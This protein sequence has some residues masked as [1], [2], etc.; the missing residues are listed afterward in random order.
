MIKIKFRFIYDLLKIAV[1]LLI[2][3]G[4]TIFSQLILDF[5]G[6]NVSFFFTD[7]FSKFKEYYP[8]FYLIL[9]IGSRT[10]KYL[11]PLFLILPVFKHRIFLF[12]ILY[13]KFHFDSITK[14][15]KSLVILFF[16]N[17]T[18][19]IGLYYLSVLYSSNFILQLRISR[20]FLIIQLILFFVIV[21]TNRVL[22]GQKV[23]ANLK[24][25][26][27][28]Y[29]LALTRILF[30]TYSIFLYLVVFPFSTNSFAGLTKVSLPGIS[31]L[32]NIWPISDSLYLWMCYLGAFSALMVAIG[33]KTRLF[34]II[35]CFTVFYVDATPNFFGKLW[36]QQILIWITWVLAVSP[37]FDVFSIDSK[38]ENKKVRKSPKYA[39]HL[40]VLFMLFGVIYFF[41]GFYKLWNGGL[42]WALSE[43]MIN[44]VR[45][46]W[47]ENYNRIPAIRIDKFPVL[48]HVVGILTI[49]FELYFIFLV[50]SKKTRWIAVFGGLI[51]HN[52]I[53]Y[54]MNIGFFVFLQAFY[55]VF[56]PWNAI[57]EKFKSKEGEL[58]IS[59]QKTPLNSLSF[60][61]PLIILF[62]NVGFS[63]FNIS[64]Y[65]FSAYPSYHDIVPA[66]FKYL[67]FKIL[68]DN[69]KNLHLWE[70]AKI[71]HFR[72]ESY[73][74]FEPEIVNR[75][76]EENQ[77][78]SSAIKLQWQRWSN[79]L[80][81][82]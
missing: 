81:H 82:Q 57:I 8:R 24:V 3:Y 14:L 71:N 11:F 5:W 32:I 9:F 44:Q 70:L 18:L 74:R 65:P 76:L 79:G 56:I 7:S 60:I 73:S 52:S 28:P 20:A 26:I 75:Y 61:L 29:N 33:Y 25:P 63:I 50:S 35:S 6:E 38:I 53:G 1:I 43:S 23:R 51:M 21:F 72:W 17:L 67:E 49:I 62:S 37:C 10:L 66:T 42:D 69:F 31:W 27:A 78:D 41:A 4:I 30:F 68:D 58:E 34:L 39:Y 48:L 13:S 15:N 40:N 12:K 2:I 77:I 80:H 54:F 64:S 22:L 46:E 55:L 59:D 45:L 36:H 16:L 19:A 47:F